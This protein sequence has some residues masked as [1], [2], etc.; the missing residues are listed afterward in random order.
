MIAT[1]ANANVASGAISAGITT[2]VSSAPLTMALRADGSEHRPDDAPISA[3][4]E[5]DGRP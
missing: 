4:D 5:L 3:C 2:F 1:P